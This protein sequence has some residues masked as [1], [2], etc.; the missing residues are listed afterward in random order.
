MRKMPVKPKFKDHVKRI[1]P[2]ATGETPT[3]GRTKGSVN[4]LCKS[5]REQMLASGIDLCKEINDLFN[6]R[7][8]QVGARIELIKLCLKYTQPAVK[9]QELSVI[10]NPDDQQPAQIP[11]TISLT[12]AIRIAKQPDDGC[13]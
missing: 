3:R 12:D 5:F 7:E 13:A 10:I 2:T 1:K 9:E 8:L 6:D 11:I 4:N